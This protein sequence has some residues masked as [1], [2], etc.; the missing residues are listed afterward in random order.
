VRVEISVCEAHEE[1]M[2]S[3]DEWVL[4][5]GDYTK[6][7][8]KVVIMGTDD[9][10]ALNEWVVEEVGALSTG[11][12]LLASDDPPGSTWHYALTAR[13]RGTDVTETLTLVVPGSLLK[14]FLQHPSD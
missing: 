2:A 10:K 1:R 12:G 7:H 14:K 4:Q 9:L 5:L 13:R 3:G 11:I 8:R 6:R